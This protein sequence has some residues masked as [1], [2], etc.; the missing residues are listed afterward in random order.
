[1]LYLGYL[2][3]RLATALLPRNAAYLV[4][5]WVAGVWWFLSPA[6]RRNLDRNLALI[7]ALRDSRALRTAVAH[8]TVRNFAVAV[9]DFLRL[10]RLNAANLD[11]VVAVED[12]HEIKRL[13]ADRPAVLVTA[14]LGNWEIAAA[15]AA[16]VGIDLSVIVWDHPDPRVAAI[17]R[18]RREAKGLKVMSVR[19]AARSMPAVVGTSSI[20]LAGDR[21]FTGQGMP[22]SFLGAPTTVPHAYAALASSR[23]IPVIPVF[24]LRLGDGRYHLFREPPLTPRPAA[25]DAEFIVDRVLRAAEKYV[26]KYPEQWYRFDS[27]GK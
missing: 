7:P 10:P 23:G 18:R 27:L 26:E 13:L 22:A 8:R 6:V 16:L 11:Q 15:G 9:T 4:A 24:C 19:G 14:H 21:D 25:D 12:F 1:M 3:A 20:A 17:F 2:A 5:T